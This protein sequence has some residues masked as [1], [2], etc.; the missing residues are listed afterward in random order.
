MSKRCFYEKDLYTLKLGGWTTDQV[1]RF[2]LG[3]I[4]RRGREAVTLVGDY[5]GDLEKGAKIWCRIWELSDLG[6][7]GPWI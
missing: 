2:F 7:L 3:E 4:D 6:R 1:E 5:D